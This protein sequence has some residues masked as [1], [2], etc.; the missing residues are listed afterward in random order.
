MYR[1]L[2]FFCIALLYSSSVLST[3]FV[4]L[5]YHDIVKSAKDNVY[6]VDR[7]S[8]RAQMNYLRDNNYHPVSLRFLDDAR[9]GKAVLP[10]KAVLIAFD[11][12]L[13]SYYDFVVPLL[14]E[15]QFPSILSVVT[16]W[17]DGEY[18][19][20]EYQGKLMSW[21]Q[22]KQLSQSPAI[23][24]I[25]H[26]H[27]LHRGIRSNPQGNEA[28][29]A[30]TRQYFPEELRYETESEYKYRAY[31]DLK[32]ATTR[33]KQQ[34]GFAPIGIAWPYGFYEQGLEAMATELGIKYQFTLKPLS[35][36]IAQL[37]RVHRTGIDG[38]YN[39]ELFASVLQAGRPKPV[40]QR[41]VGISLEPFRG[42]TPEQQQVILSRLLDRLDYIGTNT[43]VLSPFTR[44]KK[45][46]FFF[47]K[48]MP[49][50]TDILNRIL[51]QIRTRL[52][53]KYIYLELPAHI[54][55]NKPSELYSDLARLNWFNGAILDRRSTDASLQAMRRLLGSY[56]P[57]IQ[58]G[59]YTTG[60]VSGNYDFHLIELDGSKS[61]SELRNSIRN[62]KDMLSKSLY[63]V[64]RSPDTSDELLVEILNMLVSKGVIHYG[65]SYDNY[66]TDTPRAINIAGAI[67]GTQ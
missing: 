66:L 1:L 47:N 33:L 19:P 25:G 51:H 18:I 14:Q 46:A 61:L 24:V 40:R 62:K 64:R 23:E 52:G 63:L 8:F 65:Y 7:T 16:S 57:E 48:Q 55:V 44:D 67:K 32:K 36:S 10:D 56:R 35:N 22:I 2:T 29:A 11:D 6:A 53:V 34:L 41:I 43:I 31:Q 21:S 60:R 28:P 37:P 20:A 45:A 54:D 38:Q 13:R 17:L 39:I 4:V 5:T 58:I 26:T 59:R 42:R 3:E 27:A 9:N 49:V 50:A 12:G 15:Y 30:T